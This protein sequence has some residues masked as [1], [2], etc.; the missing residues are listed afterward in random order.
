MSTLTRRQQQSAKYVSRQVIRR[1]TLGAPVTDTARPVSTADNSVTS[2][3][4]VPTPKLPRHQFSR[5]HAAAVGKVATMH[6]TVISLGVKR[7]SLRSTQATVALVLLAAAAVNLGTKARHLSAPK[8][9]DVVTANLPSTQARN[10]MPS[11]IF[12]PFSLNLPGTMIFNCPT[13][14][15]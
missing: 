4:V 12:A 13:L 7:A 6:P 1:G 2:M 5:G 15:A 11:L 14:R 10:V 3:P 8:L 9:R